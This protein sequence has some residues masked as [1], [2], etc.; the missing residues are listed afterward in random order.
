M[1]RLGSGE[2]TEPERFGQLRSAAE[3]KRKRAEQGI[4]GAGGVNDVNSW[5]RDE[6]NLFFRRIRRAVCAHRYYGR[7]RPVWQPFYPGD[8]I[9][10]R[11]ANDSST[12]SLIVWPIAVAG[13]LFARGHQV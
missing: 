13:R 2:H 5:R 9:R 6:A 1:N 8:E 4:T 11:H 12:R 7:G 10:V 3:S